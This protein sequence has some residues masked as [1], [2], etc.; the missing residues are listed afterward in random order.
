MPCTSQMQII[1]TDDIDFS[2]PPRLLTAGRPG[3][4]EL[5]T[6]AGF[7]V[8]PSSDIVGAPLRLT[9]A[10][11]G[12]SVIDLDLITDGPNPRAGTP[13]EG[14]PNLVAQTYPGQHI[15]LANA[16]WMPVGP[17]IHP[18]LDPP[19][20]IRVPAIGAYVMHKGLASA[21]RSYRHKAAK[22]LVYLYEVL[23]HPN[24]GMR[25]V[26]ELAGLSQRYPE[27]Y[28]AWRERLNFV[29]ADASVRRD[30]AE[31]LVAAS[32]VQQDASSLPQL[33]AARLRRVLAETPT[34]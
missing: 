31:Q 12:D 32:R 9:Q 24:L 7:E 16:Q 29:A 30:M 28:S 22:D 5:A 26:Q 25:C 21:S 18:L 15:L 3:L 13:I 17:E 11:P 1:Y 20:Q 6:A 10:G 2:I 34:E 33:I 19:K 4:I 27:E 23:R 14:Q 8:D